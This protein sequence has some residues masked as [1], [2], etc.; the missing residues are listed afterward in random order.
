MIP[1]VQPRRA[2]VVM[3][4]ATVVSA[5]I[6]V[7]CVL[8]MGAAGVVVGALLGLG[9]LTIGAAL[10]RTPLPLETTPL[11]SAGVPVLRRPS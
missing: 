3:V 4:V 7:A 8:V 10:A 11:R 1:Q 5:V 6:F 9:V 2:V